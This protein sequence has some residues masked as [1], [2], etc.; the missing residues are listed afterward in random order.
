MLDTVKTFIKE[1]PDVP[2]DEFYQRYICYVQDQ[3]I[4]I[5]VKGI[6]TDEIVSLNK[7][8]MRLKYK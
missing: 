1:L 4:Q 2:F 5:E 3:N 8:L 6:Q 7:L